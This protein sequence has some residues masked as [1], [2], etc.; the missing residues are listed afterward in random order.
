[1]IDRLR[2]LFHLPSGNHEIGRNFG[3]GDEHESPTKK[4]PVRQGEARIFRFEII[5][6]KNIDVDDPWAPTH[7]GGSA[8]IRLHSLERGK[9]L[10]GGKPRLGKR[11]KIGE[12]FLLS[13]APRRG[14]PERRAGG[15]PRDTSSFD[16]LQSAPNIRGG[17]ADIA[18]ES[19]TDRSRGDRIRR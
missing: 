1:M 2:R 16:F 17:V 15:D 5:I 8:Q 9:E 19:E 11:A 13:A 7:A 3:K 12:V 18:A 6:E 14:A 10:G 4:L